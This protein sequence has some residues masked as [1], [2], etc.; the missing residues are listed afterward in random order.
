MTV[1][2]RLSFYFTLTISLPPLPTGT[3][4]H[5]DWVHVAQQGFVTGSWK[6]PEPVNFLKAG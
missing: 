4:R 1:K 3:L 2:L 6:T 5:V